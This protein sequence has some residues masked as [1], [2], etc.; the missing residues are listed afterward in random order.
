[1]KKSIVAISGVLQFIAAILYM[2]IF[3]TLIKWGQAENPAKYLLVFVLLAAGVQFLSIKLKNKHPEE[4]DKASN[5]VNE[6][7]IKYQ[8]IGF[9]ILGFIILVSIIVG[10]FFIK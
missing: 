2:G 4:F 1:M 8:W 5:I 7:K 10:V 3:M 6:P 9:A